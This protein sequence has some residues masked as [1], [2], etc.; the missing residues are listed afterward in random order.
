[1]EYNAM[2]VL[3]QYKELG[4]TDEQ[5]MTVV[6]MSIGDTIQVVN[7][8]EADNIHPDRQERYAGYA[9]AMGYLFELRE[10]ILKL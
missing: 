10:E 6:L 2:N 7:D 1:M 8:L 9:N 4:L 3:K 5:A